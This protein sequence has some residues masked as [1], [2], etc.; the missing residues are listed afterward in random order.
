MVGRAATSS[1]AD[2][3][4]ARTRTI[5]TLGVDLAATAAATAVAAVEWS[6]GESRLTD[7]VVGADDATIVALAGDVDTVA[8]DAPFGW[9]IAFVGFLAAH[10]LG[11]APIAALETVED[12]RELTRRRTDRHVAR[13]TRITPLMVSAD[14]IAHVALRNAGLLACLGMSDAD[15]SQGP[16]VEVYPAAALQRWGLPNRGYKGAAGATVRA[17]MV[18]ALVER[19]TGWLDLGPY[20]ATLRADDDALD[21]VVAALVGRATAIG[22]TEPPP[23]EDAAAASFEGWIQLPTCELDALIGL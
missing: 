17:G 1:A 20:E 16:V 9:P 10:N 23:P 15:R 13:T 21:A 6:A 12:R 11:R 19:T 4:S 7:L 5:R 14:R 2:S 22:R 18:D 8:I 3:S